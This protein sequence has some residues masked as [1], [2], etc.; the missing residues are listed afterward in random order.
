MIAVAVAMLGV[1]VNAASCGWGSDWV[2]MINSSDISYDEDLFSGKYWLAVGTDFSSVSVNTQGEL[3][4]ND[5]VMRLVTSADGVA[6]T[7]AEIAGTATGLSAADNNKY[8]AL[9][10]YDDSYQ[11]YGIASAMITGIVD[12][13]PADADAVTFV[14]DGD[15]Y[16]V[17]DQAAQAVPEPTSGLLL[18]LGVAGLALR[19]RRA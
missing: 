13:P 3:T 11:Y 8:L 12:D 6:H 14:N 15:A 18:L 19:R 5:E 17:L 7:G 4:Y 2:Y 10:A 16:V 9:I 1:A